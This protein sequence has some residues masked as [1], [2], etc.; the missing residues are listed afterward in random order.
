[1]GWLQFTLGIRKQLEKAMG[2]IE[3]ITLKQQ[4]ESFQFLSHF[5]GKVI[6]HQGKRNDQT[7]RY[8]PALYQIRANNSRLS[9][10]IVQVET[11]PKQLNSNFW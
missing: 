10:R 9:R 8:K 2:P 5:G 6:I 4:Q 3:V 7:G 1:M 11:D